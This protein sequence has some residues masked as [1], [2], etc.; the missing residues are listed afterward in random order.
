MLAGVAVCMDR[1]DRADKDDQHHFG[2][3]YTKESGGGSFGDE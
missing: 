3:Y 1:Y 2:I